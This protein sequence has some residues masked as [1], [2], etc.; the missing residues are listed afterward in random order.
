MNRLF[1]KKDTAPKVTL[2]DAIGLLDERVGAVD[3]K[4]SKINT[5]L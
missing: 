1:G 2:N 5:E 4:L 3:A